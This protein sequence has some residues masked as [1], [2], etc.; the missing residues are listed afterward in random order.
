M[1]KTLCMNNI[2]KKQEDRCGLPPVRSVLQGS[3]SF[4]GE[5]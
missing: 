3:L 5:V 2:L 1:L 4:E